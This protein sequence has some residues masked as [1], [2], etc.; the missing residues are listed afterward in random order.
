[1]KNGENQIRKKNQKTKVKNKNIER[2]QQYENE[3]T[4]FSFAH[5]LLLNLNQSFLQLLCPFLLLKELP[6]QILFS[7]VLPSTG[8]L[9]GKTCL[10]L[11]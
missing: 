9:P 7:L 2:T 6:V 4:V 5:L 8:G 10:K 11:C 1:M 3:K